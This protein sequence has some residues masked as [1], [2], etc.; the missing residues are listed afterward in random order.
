[1]VKASETSRLKSLLTWRDF[2]ERLSIRPSIDEK[3]GN[4]EKR[5]TIGWLFDSNAEEDERNRFCNVDTDDSAEF[6]GISWL[7][8]S[9]AWKCYQWRR[10]FCG[11]FFPLLFSSL[12]FASLRFDLDEKKNAESIR[13][14]FFLSISVLDE[15]KKEKK[16][17]NITFIYSSVATRLRE[18]SRSRPCQ[19]TVIR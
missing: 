7:N 12:L 6:N 5:K 3:I 17:D 1:M 8:S 2:E 10:Y 14:S 11:H 13:V 16:T 19:H 9:R 18:L 4:E 15:K